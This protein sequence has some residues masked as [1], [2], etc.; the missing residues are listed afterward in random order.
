MLLAFGI[1]SLLWS[2]PA[3]PLRRALPNRVRAPLG[4]FMIMAA[5]RCFLGLMWITGRAKFDLTA[6]DALRHQGALVIAPNHPSL[7][8][9]VLVISRLPRVACIAKAQLWDN[10]FLGGGI[11]LA[12]YIRNDAPL[13]LMRAGIAALRAGQPL[14]IFPEGTRSVSEPLGSFKSGFAVMARGA[15]VPVQTVFLE[16]NTPYLRKGWPLFRQP[17]L[18]LVYRAR[19]GKRF[20]VTGSTTDFVAMLEQYFRDELQGGRTQA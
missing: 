18:P 14:L 8:D 11:R 4:Q 3:G 16:S 5:F 13:A 12:G 9:A 19:L 6:L 1:A 15:G 7:L 20:E 10:L 17:A 2:I